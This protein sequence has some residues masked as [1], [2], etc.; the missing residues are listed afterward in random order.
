M[1]RSLD[2]EEDAQ[3]CYTK[4]N[5]DSKKQRLLEFILDGYA[6]KLLDKAEAV[7]MID[8]MICVTH[9]DSVTDITDDELYDEVA[10]YVKGKKQI[11][12]SDLQRRF[13]IGYGRAVQL[14]ES[15]EN[16]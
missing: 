2:N 10:S 11:S 1:K 8:D 13:K 16:N 7:E 5:M 6:N 12:T 9:S 15:L 14:K 4:I 3:V